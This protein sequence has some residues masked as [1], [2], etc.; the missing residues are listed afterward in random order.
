[1]EF[2]DRDYIKEFAYRTKYNYYKTRIEIHTDE[3]KNILDDPN[4]SDYKPLKKRLEDYKEKLN[5]T[6]I[7]MKGKDYHLDNFFEITLLLNSLVG[8][9]LFPE[10]RYLSKF[11]KKCVDYA[12]FP[13]LEAA[14]NEQKFFYSNY[15]EDDTPSNTL[16]HIRN[17]IAHRHVMVFPSRLDISQQSPGP[18]THI[19]FFDIGK[20]DDLNTQMTDITDVIDEKV[21]LKP[22]LK[23]NRGKKPIF[24]FVVK[25]SALEELLIHLCDILIN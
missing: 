3:E 9:L 11:E 19:I 22:I 25:V 2:K 24:C 12:D 21:N 5:Q 18:L 23:A 13:E 8:L 1:M 6:K 10:Q 14:H 20:E 7:E 15:D 17:A 4:C 16:R